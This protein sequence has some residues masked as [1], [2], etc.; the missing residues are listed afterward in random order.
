MYTICI[1]LLLKGFEKETISFLSKQSPK[2]RY[3]IVLI[4]HDWHVLA[5]KGVKSLKGGLKLFE[6]ETKKGKE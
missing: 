4:R 5:A 1:F 2:P 6:I 3:A